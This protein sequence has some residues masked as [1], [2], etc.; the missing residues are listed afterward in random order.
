MLDD[1]GKIILEPEG[2]ITNKE[3]KLPS[4]VIKVYLIK[5]KNLLEKKLFLRQ[6]H[7]VN[8]TLRY[9]CFEDEVFF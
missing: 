4:G 5:W 8:N 9:L 1:E 3:K 7:S 2:I 6:K